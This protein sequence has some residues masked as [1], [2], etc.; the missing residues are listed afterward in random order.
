[1]APAPIEDGSL[2]RAVEAAMGPKLASLGLTREQAEG[3]LKLSREV[4]ERVAWEV[5]PDLAETIIR[6]EIRRLT[7]G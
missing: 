5:V 3:V 7:Q 4:I 6:E 1:M 2:G